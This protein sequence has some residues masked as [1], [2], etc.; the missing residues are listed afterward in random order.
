MAGI[1]LDSGALIGWERQEARVAA[2]FEEAW[3]REIDLVVPT[4]VLAEVWRGGARSAR[5]ARLLKGCILVPLT[6]SLSRVAGEARGAVPSSGL[7]NAIVMATAVPWRAVLTGD[8]K[9]LQRLQTYFP[10]VHVLSL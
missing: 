4:V 3:E 8:R 2:H 9:D 10:A 5:V 6:E 7:V 1:V